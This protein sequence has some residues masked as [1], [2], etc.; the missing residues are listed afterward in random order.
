MSVTW[1]VQGPPAGPGGVHTK[2]LLGRLQDHSLD[3]AQVIFST[4]EGVL[5]RG[6]WP[7][8][9]D[10]IE[11]PDPGALP[12]AASM[13]NYN[14]Q[15]VSTVAGMN[16]ASGRFVAK[17]RSDLSVSRLPRLRASISGLK[18]VAREGRISAVT[19]TSVNPA[20]YPAAF[21]VCDWF[22]FAERSH[23]ARFFLRSRSVDKE[24]IQ[25]FLEL[26]GRLP[27]P[28]QFFT[29]QYLATTYGE[30]DKLL[31]EGNL[32]GGT[33]ARVHDQYMRSAFD[34]QELGDLGLASRKYLKGY[35][36]RARMYT[37]REWLAYVKTGVSRRSW[38]S[39][40]GLLPGF[41]VPR[42]L[43]AALPTPVSDALR[44]RVYEYRGLSRYR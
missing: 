40:L 13:A 11:S 35:F 32:W 16:L 42:L 29:I 7:S 20:R 22:Y 19:T 9:V 41:Y 6:S 3:A 31:M 23:L 28:E 30:V 21:A 17:L 1:L 24:S 39:D 10:Y 2:A 14:R 8:G 4:W 27:N 33:A 44:R 43:G 34:L 25:A 12:N 38:L 36:N 15:L 18:D 26:A 37:R 5:D